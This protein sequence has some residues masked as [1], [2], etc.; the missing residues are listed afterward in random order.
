MFSYT[1]ASYIA[2]LLV[3]VSLSLHFTTREDVLHSSARRTDDFDLMELFAIVI[4]TFHSLIPLQD[5]CADVCHLGQSKVLSNTDSWP[6]IKWNIVPWLWRPLLPPLWAEFI[7]WCKVG[8]GLWIQVLPSL[9]RKGGIE[10]CVA[11]HGRDVWMV[12]I[13]VRQ[14]RVRKRIANIELDQLA[15]DRLSSWSLTLTGTAG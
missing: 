6:A 4:T 15:L 2:I 13:C 9:H 10:D 12:S 11:L 14:A 7:G 3:R 5:P 1:F 8:R